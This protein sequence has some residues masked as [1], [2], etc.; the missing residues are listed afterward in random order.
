MDRQGIIFVFMEN[1]AD[2]R[3]IVA[4]VA[5]IIALASM[6][7][8]SNPAIRIVSSIVAIAVVACGMKHSQISRMG[9]WFGIIGISSL[10]IYLVRT[11]AFI[12][13]I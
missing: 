6:I 4:L 11:I 7:L 3:D 5:G 2:N 13:F 9:F 1:N 12:A 10:A 8:I